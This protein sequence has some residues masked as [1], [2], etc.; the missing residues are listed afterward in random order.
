[1]CA[2]YGI[3]ATGPNCTCSFRECVGTVCFS[4]GSSRVCK[5]ETLIDEFSHLKP[6]VEGECEAR[7][8]TVWLH[9]GSSMYRFTT[10]RVGRVAGR[11]PRNKCV[12]TPT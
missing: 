10:E 5:M 2:L 7:T 4:L 8:E 6:C 3:E 9:S 11:V 12:H 1:M